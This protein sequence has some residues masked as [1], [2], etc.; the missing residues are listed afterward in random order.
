MQCQADETQKVP[1]VL[2]M[3]TLAYSKQYSERCRSLATTRPTSFLLLPNRL[4]ALGVR[5]RTPGRSNWTRKTVHFI[6]TIYRIDGESRIYDRL[7]P[8]RRIAS[9]NRSRSL[10]TGCL[11]IWV[12]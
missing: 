12:A 3:L 5:F 1:Y 11:Q 6:Y 10:L 8:A 2:D 9:A 4:T 7:T